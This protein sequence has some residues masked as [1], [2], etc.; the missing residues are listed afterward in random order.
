[1]QRWALTILA[2]GLFLPGLTARAASGRVIKVLPQYLDLKGRAAVAP[3]LFERDAYQAR[4]RQHPELRS[5]LRFEVQWK[6]KD[7]ADKPL[8]LRVELRGGKP[9][10]LPTQTVLEET[11]R[12]K[13]SFSH[14]TAVTLSGEAYQKFGEL[15]AWRATLWDGDVMLGEQKSFLW[16]A[17]AGQ[18]ATGR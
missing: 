18:P 5:G 13:G 14:W 3:S 6:A 17:P 2:L 11:V 9:D 16:S 7:T 15:V 12:Q 10:G 4:L 8:T 1:M